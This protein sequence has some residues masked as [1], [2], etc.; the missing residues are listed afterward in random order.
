ME[1][2][3]KCQTFLR[4]DIKGTDDIVTG[5]RTILIDGP[6]SNENLAKTH[7]YIADAKERDKQTS[8]NAAAKRSTPDF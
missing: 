1:W 8:Q 3:K 5:I 7:Q 6:K 2:I 4:I